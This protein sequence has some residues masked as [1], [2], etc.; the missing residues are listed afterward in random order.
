MVLLPGSKADDHQWRCRLQKG[1]VLKAVQA[2]PINQL[3]SRAQGVIDAT[4]ANSTAAG[5]RARQVEFDALPD[6]STETGLTK[7][8][9]KL[10]REQFTGVIS[11]TTA[12]RR[13]ENERKK[14]HT[15]GGGGGG[16]I[17]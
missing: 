10:W 7:A 9:A 11:T 17:F 5:K 12:R 6:Y 1:S 14:R 8:A 2:M 3:Q 15:E 13:N 4:P 16:W